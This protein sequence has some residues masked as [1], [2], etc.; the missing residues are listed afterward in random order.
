VN[1]KQCII[2]YDLDDAGDKPRSALSWSSNL[3]ATSRIFWRQLREYSGGKCENILEI[4]E[5]PRRSEQ[6]S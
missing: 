4:P 3:E 5:I 1:R 2:I 6:R